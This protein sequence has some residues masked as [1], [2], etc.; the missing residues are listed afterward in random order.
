MQWRTFPLH[1]ET[2]EEGQLLEDLFKTSPEKI[3][4]MV[5]QLRLTALNLGLP[6]GERTKT[7]N[8]RLA[9][10]LGLWAEDMGKGE[11]FHNL[12]FKAYFADGENLAKSSVLLDLAKKAGLHPEEAEAI[13]TNRTYR[14]KV[15]KD[16]ADSRFMG[17]TA[18]PTFLL[19]QHKLVGAQSYEAFTQL[20]TQYNIPLNREN[21]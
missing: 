6:F 2:P 12:A 3:K 8:S 21:R 7:Y 13:I 15:D 14:Q 11:L 5:A 4:T 9:Q 19:G 1:P 20:M 18:V 16:W 10:E 17:I